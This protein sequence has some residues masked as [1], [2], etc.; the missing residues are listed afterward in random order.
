M[1]RDRPETLT[2]LTG[3]AELWVRGV[4]VD[5]A[6]AFPGTRVVDLPTYA[7]QRHRYWLDTA[8]GGPL[9]RP[10]IDLPDGRTEF[11]GCLSTRSHP[12]LA[13]HT[14]ADTVLVPAAAFAEMALQAAAHAGCPAIG[15]LILREPLVAPERGEAELL[16]TV[17]PPGDAPDE[18]GRA[19]TIHARADG[20][21]GW[22]LHATGLL[23]TVAPPPPTGGTV[24]ADAAPLPVDDLYERLADA[25]YKYGPGFQGLRAAWRQGADVYAEIRLPAPAEPD[26]YGIHPAL[27][28]AALHTVFLT[29]GTDTVRVPFEWR[30]VVLHAEGAD[31]VVVHAVETGT[32]TLSLA[33]TDPAGAPVAT[34]GMVT[35]RPLPD[36]AV[37]RGATV[38]RSMF[39]IAWEPAAVTG[40]PAGRVAVVGDATTEPPDAEA[41]DGLPALREA[42]RGGAPP[43]VAVVDIVPD[44]AGETFRRAHEVTTRTLRLLQDW[45]RDETLAG[46]RLTIVTRRA[47]ATDGDEPADPAAAAVWGLV[48]SAQAENP[49]RIVLVDNACGAD[50]L[51]TALAAGEEQVAVRGGEAFVPRLH[52]IRPD[53]DTPP[54]PLDPG[55]TVLVTGGTGTLGGLVARHLAAEHGARH[56]LLASRR[57]ADA[58]GYAELAGEL[59][60][61]GAEVT[62]T[63]CDVADR[64]AVRALLAGVSA[65][66]PLGAVV[67]AAGTLADSLVTN[68]TDEQVADVLGPKADAAWHLHELT[69][70]L[71][72][73]AFVLFSSVAGTIGTP[74]QANYAAANAFL[75]ALARDRAAQGLPAISL[76]WGLWEPGSGMTSTLDDGDIARLHRIGLVP[77]PTDRGLRLFDAALATTHAVVVAAGL[78]PARLRANAEAGT[79]APPLRSLVTGPARRRATAGAPGEPDGAVPLAA[80]LAGLGAA[81]RE[82]GVVTAVRELTATVLAHGSVAEDRTFKALGFDSLTAVDLRNRLD[83]ITGL[84]LPATIVFDHP[85]PAVLGRHV[86]TL[87]FPDAEPS[88]GLL[89]G[90]DRLESALSA[91]SPDEVATAVGDEPGLDKV[92]GRMRRLLARWADLRGTATTTPTTTPARPASSAS[93]DELFALLDRRHG[94]GN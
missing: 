62:A 85:T 16:L 15:E 86:H 46:V 4:D 21:P 33:L 73:D 59:R 78:D 41:Y 10:A 38:A 57:G 28:D 23:A 5:W 50:G 45:L 17:D 2:W 60:A 32:D 64:D 93:D 25:G 43:D 66:H 76:A 80:R 6:Q 7:F 44:G 94:N 30:D 37:S 74:G 71:P 22:T 92:T 26:A 84:R 69:R 75:D 52:R 12:W 35:T 36:G 9:L 48:Q 29:G 1:R 83:T 13:E 81:E 68:M 70:D 77:L 51:L 79:L 31:S 54:F 55:R 19:F 63:A 87:L 14:V 18:T 89:D 91:L 90:L 20:D 3:L 82:R 8:A 24:P 67:H 88:A 39:G 11:V 72:L 65:E 56:L 40:A 53:G 61:L 27:L 49:G 34:I 42:V 47:V 58:A